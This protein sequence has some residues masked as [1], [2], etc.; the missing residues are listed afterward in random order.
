MP[1]VV[2]LNCGAWYFGWS[3]IYDDY[4]ICDNCGFGIPLIVG[5]ADYSAI[6]L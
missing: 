4:T 3:L 5:G 1:K 6:S 2:C